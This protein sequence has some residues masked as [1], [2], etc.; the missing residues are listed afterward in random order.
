MDKF[1]NGYPWA[2]RDRLLKTMNWSPEGVSWER[3][4]P[5][6]LNRLFAKLAPLEGPGH[7]TP[8]TV[9]HGEQARGISSV[10]F[11]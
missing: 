2:V 1:E 5:K 10:R 11:R 9:R 3:W 4:K 8:E 7:I 6:S